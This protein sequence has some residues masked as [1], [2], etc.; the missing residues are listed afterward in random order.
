M[1]GIGQRGGG[2]TSLGGWGLPR[3]H[4]GKEYIHL[5]KQEMQE[6]QVQPL[7][8][9]VLLEG[10]MATHS[11]ILAW[12]IPWWRLQSMGSP[13]HTHTHTPSWMGAADWHTR[14]MLCVWL[15]QLQRAL[16]GSSF[17]QVEAPVHGSHA[18]PPA[19]CL[20]GSLAAPSVCLPVR[21]P[22]GCPRSSRDGGAQRAPCPHRACLSPAYRGSKT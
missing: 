7:G 4:R 14:R 11:S 2:S 12:R 9:E 8:Q 5:P 10:E 1:G 22:Q 18:A 21:R 15:T 19:M 3:W 20:P 17:Q 16:G 13:T 6:T